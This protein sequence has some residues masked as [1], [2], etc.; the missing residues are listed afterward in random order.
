[1]KGRD[2]SISSTFTLCGKLVKFFRSLNPEFEDKTLGTYFLFQRITF[3]KIEY[4]SKQIC[5][6]MRIFMAKKLKK[7]GHKS[8][9]TKKTANQN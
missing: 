9:G 8:V 7:I 6:K 3:G 2:L 5:E 1:M 4:Y